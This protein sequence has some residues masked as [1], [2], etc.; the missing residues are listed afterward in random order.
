MCVSVCVRYMNL[1]RLFVD[2]CVIS[3]V[4]LSSLA[5]ED[6]FLKEED[7][8]ETLFFPEC[9]QELILAPQLALL[10]QINLQPTKRTHMLSVQILLIADTV[11]LQNMNFNIIL[12]CEKDH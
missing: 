5:K 2:I 3:Y 12:E 10:L 11:K 9:H 4:R 7:V 8:A 1:E 6:E